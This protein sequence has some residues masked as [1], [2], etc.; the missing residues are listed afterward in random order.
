MISPKRI[1]TGNSNLARSY[2]LP[3][4]RKIR[5]IGGAVGG[6]GVL[7]RRFCTNQVRSCERQTVYKTVCVTSWTKCNFVSYI[8]VCWLTIQLQYKNDSCCFKVLIY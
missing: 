4:S 3:S 7:Y 8:A 2:M 6:T 1:E 5:P